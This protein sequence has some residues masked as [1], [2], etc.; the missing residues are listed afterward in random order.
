MTATH[1]VDNISDANNLLKDGWKLKDHDLKV[2]AGG[3]GNGKGLSHQGI[4][5]TSNKMRIIERTFVLE[6]PHAIKHVRSGY[7]GGCDGCRGCHYT[8]FVTA[9]K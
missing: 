1:I 6:L 4:V 7:S 9:E 3:F 2:S 8:G 5:N